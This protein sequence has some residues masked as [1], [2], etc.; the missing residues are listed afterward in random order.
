MFPVVS[1]G[2]GSGQLLREVCN[3]STLWKEHQGNYS[4]QIRFEDLSELPGETA[5]IFSVVTTSNI[6]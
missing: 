1:G 2:K 5:P 6:M 3:Y 4:Q